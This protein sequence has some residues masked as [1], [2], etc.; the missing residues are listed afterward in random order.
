MSEVFQQL[1][2]MVWWAEVQNRLNGVL[3]VTPNEQSRLKWCLDSDFH[4]SCA[5]S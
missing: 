2:C 1:I 3:I 5:Q 4:H